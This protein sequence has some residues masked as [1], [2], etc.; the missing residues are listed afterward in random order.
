MSAISAV[1][2][3]GAT[4]TD[5]ARAALRV[6]RGTPSTPPSMRRRR[7]GPASPGSLQA[8]RRP[9]R[10]RRERPSPRPTQEAAESSRRSGRLPRP[11]VRRTCC[12]A[13]SGPPRGRYPCRRP[14]TI[15]PDRPG[16]PA[17]RCP[18]K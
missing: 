6:F 9:R 3:K 5:H 15:R 18:W 1:H 2:R 13:G 17:F 16:S 4:P 12:R 8:S 10:F 7:T 11:S 14:F